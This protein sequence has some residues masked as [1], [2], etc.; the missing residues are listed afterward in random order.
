MQDICKAYAEDMNEEWV[1]YTLDKDDRKSCSMQ[2]GGET[3]FK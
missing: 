2:E 1:K 3:E